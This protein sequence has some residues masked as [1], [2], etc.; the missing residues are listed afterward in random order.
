MKDW[1]RDCECKFASGA[2]LLPAVPVY[3]LEPMKH[4]LILSALLAGLVINVAAAEKKVVD[5]KDAK[6]Q[7]VGT[8]TIVN[9]GTGVK[10]S[11]D[12]KSLTPGEHGRSKE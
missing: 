2:R 4:L 7:A 10:I 5:I 8:A 6:G 9:K 3:N 12:L 1:L 11:L